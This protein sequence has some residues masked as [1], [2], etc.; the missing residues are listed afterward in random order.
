VNITILDYCYEVE[1]LREHYDI[2]LHGS[3]DPCLKQFTHVR[4]H[5]RLRPKVKKNWGSSGG[6]DVDVFECRV[7]L[8]GFTTHKTNIAVKSNSLRGTGYLSIYNS[9][10]RNLLNTTR[11]YAFFEQS[12]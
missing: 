1:T 3:T 12:K 5:Y 6:E 4:H 8:E 11:F 10:P 7:D 2:R 9:I